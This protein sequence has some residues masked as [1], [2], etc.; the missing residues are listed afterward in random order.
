MKRL[1]IAAI[2]ISLASG[3][4]PVLAGAQFSAESVQTTAQG[5]ATTTKVFVGDNRVR[6]EG[7]QNGQKFAQVAD[8]ANGVTYVIIPDQRSYMEMR[9]P[10]A[11][12]TPQGKPVDPCAN[13]QGVTCRKIGSESVSGRAATRW[14]LTSSAGGQTR[15]MNQWIDD[16][17]G[18]PLRIQAS[19]GSATEAKLVAKEQYEGRSVE[20]WEMTMSRA[21]QQPVT[22]VQWFDPELGVPV[23]G[24]GPDGSTFEL[25]GIRVGAQPADLFTV[26]AGFQKVEPPQAQ[27]GATPQQR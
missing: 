24:K 26:P 2:G 18:T 7:A 20:K 3:A 9:V 14:E 15:S 10:V 21:G 17:R 8:N 1:L 23:R 19:D 4:S 25:R 11:A 12:P 16:E 13:L 6:T 22:S 27:P 5:Q